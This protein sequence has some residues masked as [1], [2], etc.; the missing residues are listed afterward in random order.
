MIPICL[1]I[2]SRCRRHHLA[3]AAYASISALSLV[4]SHDNVNTRHLGTYELEPLQACNICRLAKNTTRSNNGVVVDRLQPLP[5]YPALKSI[6]HSCVQNWEFGE[7]F[8]L[9][10][11]HGHIPGGHGVVSDIVAGVVPALA[12]AARVRLLGAGAEP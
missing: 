3:I 4:A 6:G 1:V 5:L 11:E 2:P 12:V 8:A 7:D 10:S 9:K